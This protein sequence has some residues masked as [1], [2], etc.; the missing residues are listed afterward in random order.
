LHVPVVTN[1]RGEKLSKQNGATALDSDKPLEALGAA[2]QHLGLD[3]GDKAH[4]TLDSFY[5]AATAAWARRM[6]VRASA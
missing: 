2:A 3:L 1:E 6:G 5:T 4:T